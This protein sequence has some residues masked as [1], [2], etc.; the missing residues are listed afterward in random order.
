MLVGNGELDPLVDGWS[1]RHPG[2]IRHLPYDEQLARLVYGGADAYLMPS[3]FE[4]CGIGQMYAMR[5]GC[6]PVVHLTG[7]LN[8]T[9]VDL[10]E[11]PDGG[12]GFGFRLPI[13]EELGQVDPPR[14]PRLQAGSIYLA[15]HAA[16]RDGARLVLGRRRRPLPRGVPPSDGMTGP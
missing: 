11:D 7:G 2:A 8:D 5:Y 15:G 9:V 13:V 4:P 10:D 14:Y 3:L 12:M 1:A 6:P 16:P